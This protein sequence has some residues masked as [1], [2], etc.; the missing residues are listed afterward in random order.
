MAASS[1]SAKIPDFEKVFEENESF[2]LKGEVKNLLG[3][4]AVSLK[5]MLSQRPE[6]RGSGTMWGKKYTASRY[7]RSYFKDYKFRGTG[8]ENGGEQYDSKNKWHVYLKRLVSLC[9]AYLKQ[10]G[11]S[12]KANGVLVNW[13][14][15]GSDKIGHHSDDQNGLVDGSPIFSFSF[16]MTRDFHIRPRASPKHGLAVHA[17]KCDL[18]LGNG[19]IV[20]MGGTLQSTHTHAVPG[21]AVSRCPSPRVNIT[22]RCF[23]K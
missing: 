11:C 15:D 6:E 13:Y 23:K 2:V 3:R 10:N 8:E 22:I 17:K 16:G 21:R 14:M 4:G 9:N 12:Y 7:Y 19:D 20:I 5:Y 1:T 18:S